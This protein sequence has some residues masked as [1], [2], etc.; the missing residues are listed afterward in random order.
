MPTV[1]LRHAALRKRYGSVSRATVDRLHAAGHL[2]PPCYPVNPHAPLWPESL[3]DL[4][5]GADERERALI[6]STWP[7]WRGA[8]AQIERERATAS[9]STPQAP[10]RRKRRKVA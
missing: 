7:D 3:L 9:E 6:L 5:D 8:L 1:W 10:R 4:W 2:P